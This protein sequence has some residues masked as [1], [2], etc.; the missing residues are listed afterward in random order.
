VSPPATAP[1]ARALAARRPILLGLA[2]A[3]LAAPRSG[4]ATETE[5]EYRLVAARPVAERLASDDYTL[6][7]RPDRTAAV[8]GEG[9]RLVPLASH[10]LA[11]SPEGALCFCGDVLFHDDFE[12]GG[13]GAWS[14]TAP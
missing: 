11:V 4:I 3:A 2:V 5:S 9:Y 8:T 12:S 1:T 6:Q 10:A 7:P 14:D 13:T